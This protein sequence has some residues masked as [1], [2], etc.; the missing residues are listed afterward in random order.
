MP[1]TGTRMH[2][3]DQI[4]HSCT[5]YRCKWVRGYWDGEDA[6]LTALEWALF[7]QDEQ[8]HSFFA[9]LQ[10]AA[11]AVQELMNRASYFIENRR[12]T[13]VWAYEQFCAQ[14]Q[15]I[16]ELSWIVCYV[17]IGRESRQK[18]GSSVAHTHLV[19]CLARHSK[20]HQDGYLMNPRLDSVQCLLWG[21]GPIAPCDDSDR[22]LH[23]KG[24]QWNRYSMP[25]WNIRGV[26]SSLF[27][28]A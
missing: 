25:G 18:P 2:S 5:A 22:N 9:Q 17:V 1:S 28:I 7:G 27:G 19:L 20:K 12:Y 11:P 23:R 3:P 4:P 6:Y 13:F 8:T 24:L 14:E 15:A 16:V 10:P 26:M 21:C